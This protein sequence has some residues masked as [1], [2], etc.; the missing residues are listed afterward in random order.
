MI[1]KGIIISKERD[2]NKYIVRI[3]T[4]EDPGDNGSN[5]FFTATLCKDP[6]MSDS[7]KN[8]DVVFI[9]F[10]DHKAES[11][12]ILG[13]LG[14]NDSSISG[15]SSSLSALNVSNKATLPEDT[16]IGD[17][18]YEMLKEALRKLHM[19]DV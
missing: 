13:A 15:G 2:S 12:V 6:S 17:I 4:L 1:T 9:G 10:E 14:L 11:P 19:L 3:P 16:T 18:T 8:G 5:P 7:Y